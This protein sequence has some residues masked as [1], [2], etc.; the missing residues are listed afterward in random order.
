MDADVE[1]GTSQVQRGPGGVQSTASGGP[2]QSSATTSGAATR[3]PSTTAFVGMQRHHGPALVESGMQR[4]S[5]RS[6]AKPLVIG[7]QRKTTRLVQSPFSAQRGCERHSDRVRPSGTPSP[8][9]S[10]SRGSVPDASFSK[11]SKSPSPSVSWCVPSWK[12]PG[13]TGVRFVEQDQK[14]LV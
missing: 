10:G 8:S 9:V 7:S 2:Y 11:E 4:S 6:A 14:A 1:D 5:N 13:G 3:A 12:K